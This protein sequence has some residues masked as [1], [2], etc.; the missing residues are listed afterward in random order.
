MK[1]FGVFP[2]TSVTPKTL[3]SVTVPQTFS[4][5]FGG[6][7]SSEALRTDKFNTYYSIKDLMKPETAICQSDGKPDPKKD[8]FSYLKWTP[9]VSSLLI[10]SDLGIKD[11][12]IGAMVFNIFLPSSL[13][14][15]P[16]SASNSGENSKASSK[17]NSKG[18]LKAGPKG[19]SKEKL[20]VAVG[21]LRVAVDHLRAAVD[22]LRA[23]VDHRRVVV[24]SVKIYFPRNQV[25]YRF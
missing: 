15:S 10:E 16:P 25:H 17:E 18:R 7:L 6:T 19:H 12:L 21:H 23:A 5:G 24:D 9:A 3:N 14:P 13:Q 1:I 2:A 22:H 4:L 11:W 20:R 8:P